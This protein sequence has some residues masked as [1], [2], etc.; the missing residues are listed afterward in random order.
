MDEKSFVAAP[1][2]IKVVGVGGGGG[3]AIGRLVNADIDGVQ[4]VVVNTD[5]QAL[6]RNETS[7]RVQI[8]EKL[9]RGLGA[10]GN[11][12]VGSEAAIESEETLLEIVEDT[13][14]IFIAAGMGGG[15]GTGAAPV[16]AK[17]AK[18][19]GSLA[20]GIVT[21]PFAFEG[22]RRR[23]I[24]TEGVE[25]LAVEADALIAIDNDRLFH[26][27]DFDSRLTLE[28]AFR[29]IDEILVVAVQ[30]I[31]EIITRPGLVNV[32]F[33]DVRSILKDGGPAWL[34]VGHGNG[35]G[36]A[37][38][39]ARRAVES[40]LSA[41]DMRGA[42]RILF[43]I[44]GTNN[45]T[46]TEVNEAASVIRN[47]AAPDANII[48]GVTFDPTLDEGVRLVLLATEFTST[49][50]AVVKQRDDKL[51]HLLDGADES[52]LD[53]PAFMRQSLSLRS[54]SNDDSKKK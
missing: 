43:T 47:E 44:A 22:K 11:P 17:L 29:K 26:P 21:K 15:T 54:L 53:V 46:L 5:A 38:D 6:A 9:T 51:R 16:V 40:P 42:K 2:R 35:Q 39:A 28:S 3:N 23:Q 7:T 37:V 49:R 14:M 24:A 19:C 33:A 36:R 34:S 30:A 10:G 8:G 27:S 18:A 20:I 31:T 1:I 41:A 4:C 52:E 32:D 48:F 13:D 25:R 50:D 12:H 45:L